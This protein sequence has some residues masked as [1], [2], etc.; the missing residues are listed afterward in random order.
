MQVFGE[1]CLNNLSLILSC[2]LFV[3]SLIIA[4]LKKRPIL[5]QIDEIKKV[6]LE[7]VPQYIKQA[8]VSGMTGTEKFNY[9]VL[10]VTSLISRKF[11]IGDCDWLTEFLTISIENVLKAP[12]ATIYKK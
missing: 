4:L 10:K 9:V 12:Q 1:W 11:N 3:L 7:V 8:E 5:N 2:L 6:V